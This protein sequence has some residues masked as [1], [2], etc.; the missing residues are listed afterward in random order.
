MK[1]FILTV[2]AGKRLIGRGMAAHPGVADALPERTVVIVAGT[3]NAYV[4]EEVLAVLGQ[5]EG[6]HREGFR[7]GVTVPPGTKAPPGRLAGDVVI[8]RGQWQRGKQVFDVIGEMREGDVVIKGANALDLVA[9]RAAVLVG[10]PQAGTIGAILPAVVGRRV[11]LIVP[12]GLEKRV[13]EDLDV[14]AARLNAPGAEGPRMMP[15]AGEVFTELDAIERLTGAKAFLAAAGGVLG[16]E[17][18]CWIGVD[19]SHEQ[20]QAAEELIRAVEAE[21]PT[22]P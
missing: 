21:P 3:T 12:V 6:F 20:L 19:G 17:G 22:N 2:S 13:A 11:R 15:I 9:R 7:R 18:A 8:H 10:H 16:A 5:A 1:Q 4:A 14:L